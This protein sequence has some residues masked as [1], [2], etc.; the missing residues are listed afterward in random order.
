MMNE[1]EIDAG[2][3]HTGTM[4]ELVVERCVTCGERLTIPR[5]HRRLIVL[6][7]CTCG[8]RLKYDQHGVQASGPPE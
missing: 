5:P 1:I 6:V 7:T 4:V 8:T 3:G 2:I